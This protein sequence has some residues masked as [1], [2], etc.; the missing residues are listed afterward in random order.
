MKL[1]TQ[2]MQL[3]LAQMKAMHGGMSMAPFMKSPTGYEASPYLPGLDHTGGHSSSSGN[4]TSPENDE[5][6]Y[7][8]QPMD[9]HFNPHLMPMQGYSYASPT[10]VPG[11]EHGGYLPGMYAAVPTMPNHHSMIPPNAPLPQTSIKTEMP[12]PAA[13][14][15][16][17][18]NGDNQALLDDQNTTA[19]TN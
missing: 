4:A 16:E 1:R 19:A 17:T 18:K 5:L 13:V 6:M 12:P 14:V 11:N 9:H 8:P 15:P 3:M 10:F 7:L 2:Y